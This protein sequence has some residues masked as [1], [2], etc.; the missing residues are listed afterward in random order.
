MARVVITQL[1]H[2]IHPGG[3]SEGEYRLRAKRVN[4]SVIRLSRKRGMEWLNVTS[5]GGLMENTSA[6]LFSK[7]GYS[8]HKY[9]SSLLTIKKIRENSGEKYTTGNIKEI[10]LK[11]ARER[12]ET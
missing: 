9:L 10:L 4:R 8:N 1:V 3:L 5:L 7:D 2:R 11:R 6:F 12:W